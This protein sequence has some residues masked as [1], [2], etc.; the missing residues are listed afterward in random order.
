MNTNKLI[1]RKAELDILEKA[2][3]SDKAEMVAIF[4]RRRVGKTFLVNAAYSGIIDFEITGI[5]DAPLKRQLKNFVHQMRQ[6]S[7]VETL[8]NMPDDWFDAFV[9]LV[10]FLKKL[11]DNRKRVVFFDELPWMATPRSGFL[12]GLSHFWNSWAVKQNIV[13]VI[14]GSAASWMIQKVV[15]HKGGLHN[16]ITKR[17][18]LQPFKLTW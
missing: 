5:Q 16:R 2:L 3:A 9:M 1:G 8:A 4:G 17:I 18:Y 14:C 11:P 13:V 12:Q 6:F 7:G 15:N 10:D